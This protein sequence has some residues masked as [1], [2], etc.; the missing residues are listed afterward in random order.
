MAAEPVKANHKAMSEAR[1]IRSFDKLL[2]LK[3]WE[4]TFDPSKEGGF[5]WNKETHMPVGYV[6]SPFWRAKE[7]DETV[8][9]NDMRPMFLT[10][11]ET[12]SLAGVETG[13]ELEMFVWNPATND[14]APIM[15]EAS[16]V[17][18]TLKAINNGDIHFEEE[19]TLFEELHP[20]NKK[21]GFSDELMNSCIELN[22]H[23][24]PDGLTAALSTAHSLKKLAKLAETEGWL[25]SPIAAFAPHELRK[26]DTNQ[27]SYVQRIAHDYMGWENVRHFIGS[28]FQVHVEMLDLESSLKTI[29]MYQHIAPLLYAVSL[30]G[31]FAHGSTHPNLKAMYEGDEYTP[32]RAQDSETYAQ[33]DSDD[34]MSI[35]YP[36]RW[37]GSPSGGSYEEPLPETVSAFFEYTEKG[38]KNND[39]H[40][41]DNIPSPARAAGHHRDRIRTDIGPNGTLEIS[42][43]DT[44]GGN[45][46]KLAA[47]QEF[48]KVLIWK[49]QVYAK[50]GRM[51]E[52]AQRFPAMFP[53]E[54]TNDSLRIAHL[55][56][57]EVAKKGIEA[58]MIG[59]DGQV[60]NAQDLFLDL[61]NFVNEPMKDEGQDID[62]KGLQPNVY[63]EV[64]KSA[65]VPNSELYSK[66]KDADN[67]TSVRGFYESGYGT[68]SHWLKQRAKD[69]AEL[70]MPEEQIIQNCMN[71]LGLSY[72]DFLKSLNGNIKEL[73][74]K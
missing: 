70:E 37:R 31:P 23:H 21:I 30:A 60:Y 13:A 9:E 3:N 10:P 59:T 44:F 4:A 2:G 32:K 61:A 17:P 7:N 52:L 42:N 56:S 47:I 22:F 29:N 68:L 20:D 49:M 1:P 58:Q 38:L 72:H 34:W 48:T 71:D 12:A 16:S 18:K 45:V 65:M 41:P 27:D 53:Q 14:G 33:L 43:M 62:F 50:S 36:A 73:F 55:N 5:V 67:A 66:Y 51:A 46:L 24:T 35:R 40:S 28:S 69:L 63:K 8:H 26:E 25:L 64:V 74:G 15:G 6:R 39:P 11:K 19:D 57:I 54:T